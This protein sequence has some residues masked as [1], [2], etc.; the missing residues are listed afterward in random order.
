MAL[1]P[2][3]RRT[4]LGSMASVALAAPGAAAPAVLT[5]P[6]PSSG[7]P[8]PLVGLGSWITFNV[9]NDPPARENCGQVMR[10]FFAAGG[11][12]IDSSPMYGSSQPVI[13]EGLKK[14]GA[15]NVFSADKVWTSSG[16]R[17]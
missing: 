15:A 4:L 12:M 16:W 10:A 13:G 5:R 14:V 6:I 7:E 1:V 17:R 8:L 3:T 9:G 2:L 11:R